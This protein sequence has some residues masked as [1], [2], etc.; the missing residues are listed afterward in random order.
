MNEI[1]LELAALLMTLFCLV[2]SVTVRRDLY[3]PLPRGLH[4]ALTSQHFIFLAMLVSVNISA[5]SS[6][7]VMLGSSTAPAR[8]SSWR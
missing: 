4:A 2:C 7:A 5:A 6:V 1:I 3:T 8:R